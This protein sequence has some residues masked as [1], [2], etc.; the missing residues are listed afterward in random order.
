MRGLPTV[1]VGCNGSR[2]GI[3]LEEDELLLAAPF[4][5]RMSQLMIKAG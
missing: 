2:P 5:S 1:S 4:G 3:N